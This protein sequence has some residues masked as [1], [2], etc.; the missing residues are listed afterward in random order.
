MHPAATF[1]HNSLRNQAEKHNQKLDLV[2]SIILIPAS[3]LVSRRSFLEIEKYHK[4]T[5]KK[6]HE[7]EP[8]HTNLT[9]HKHHRRRNKKSTFPS[10]VLR[11]SQNSHRRRGVCR[12]YSQNTRQI[13]Q[14][15]LDK[16]FLH[17]KE[18]KITTPPQ[19]TIQH[20]AQQI[21]LC[22]VTSQFRATS[23]SLTKRLGCTLMRAS[24]TSRSYVNHWSSYHI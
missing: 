6:R 16:N 4:Y 9:L 1:I 19:T 24:L 12:F 8:I 3:S 11:S 23:K 17:F 15:P 18:S 22:F 20:I 5:K 7:T 14:N 13:M 2:N 21:A 10:T